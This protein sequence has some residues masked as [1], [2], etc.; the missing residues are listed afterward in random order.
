MAKR[1]IQQR[2]GR[3][4]STYRVP[5]KSFM[6]RIQYKDKEGIVRDIVP[7]SLMDSPLA[8]VEYDDKTS[9]HIIAP[10]GTKLGTAQGESY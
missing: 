9:G 2:R 4:T 6:P 7:Y 8:R 1:I 3:G 5:K 10:E